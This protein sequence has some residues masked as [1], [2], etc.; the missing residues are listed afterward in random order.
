M[1]RSPSPRAGRAPAHPAKGPQ[2]VGTRAPRKA[3][4]MSPRDHADRS[5]R[6]IELL[7]TSRELWRRNLALRAA[8]RESRADLDEVIAEFHAIRTGTDS[9][10][11][12]SHG[13]R[14]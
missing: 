14:G 8:L 5:R 13:A 1:L 4:E 6:T 12:G 11:P 10:P 2:R 7:T 9:G 3:G